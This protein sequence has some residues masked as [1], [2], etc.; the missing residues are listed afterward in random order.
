MQQ[1]HPKCRD[2]SQEKIVGM[3]RLQHQTLSQ[4]DKITILQGEE[5]PVRKTAR[6]LDRNEAL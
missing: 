4:P 3:K 1:Y 2:I 5:L 6:E